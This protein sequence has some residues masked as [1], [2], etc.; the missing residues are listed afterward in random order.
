MTALDELHDLLDDA[1]V[2]Y[3]GL[4]VSDAIAVILDHPDVVLRA[5]GGTRVDEHL[6]SD[7]DYWSFPK[8][9]T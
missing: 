5:L 6:E 3:E 7:F 4:S 9:V 1:F 8:A 2:P